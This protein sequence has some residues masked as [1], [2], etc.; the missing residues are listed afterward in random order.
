[1]TQSIQQK[2]W[3]DQAVLGQVNMPSGYDNADTSVSFP[4]FVRSAN[5]S[6]SIEI[7]EACL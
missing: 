3:Q 5:S 6:E 2:W 1:M 7:I 4:Y